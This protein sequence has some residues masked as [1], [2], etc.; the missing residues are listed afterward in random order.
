MATRRRHGV[1]RAA[2]THHLAHPAGADVRPR[3]R[4]TA[5]H[6]WWREDRGAAEPLPVLATMR[7]VLAERYGVALDSIGLNLYRD[8]HDSVAW[9]RDRHRRTVRQPV[10]AIVSVGD[11]RPFRLRPRGGGAP[12]AF[13]LGHGDLFVMGGSCQHDWEHTVPKCTAGVGPRISI[14]FRHGAER[15][16]R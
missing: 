16:P 4:R 14:T 13:E 11:R 7:A 6:G 2:R 12:V 9:H 3:G 15:P 5:L 10:V 1:R 8:R